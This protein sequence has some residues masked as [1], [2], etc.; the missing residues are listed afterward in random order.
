MAIGDYDWAIEELA[1]EL[2]PQWQ[3]DEWGHRALHMAL[4]E[5]EPMGYQHSDYFGHTAYHGFIDYMMNEYDWDFE[6]Y[7]DWDAYREWYDSL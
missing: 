2:G 1:G 4:Y 6:E 5:G 3:H 7:F